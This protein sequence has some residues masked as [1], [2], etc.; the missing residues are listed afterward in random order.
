[1]KLTNNEIINIGNS[2]EIKIEK[3]IK[4][5]SKYLDAKIIIKNIPLPEGGPLGD[6]QI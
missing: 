2:A 3:V 6:V 4:I 1:M 5:I